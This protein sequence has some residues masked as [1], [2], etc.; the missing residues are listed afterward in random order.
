M[1]FRAAGANGEKH[2]ELN[3]FVMPGNNPGKNCVHFS[4]ATA[5]KNNKNAIFTLNIH[6][7]QV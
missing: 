5:L 2:F 4:D 6:K 7:N 1:L 3:F